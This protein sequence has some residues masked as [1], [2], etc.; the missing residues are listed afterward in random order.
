MRINWFLPFRAKGQ[1][2]PG[3]SVL[4]WLGPTWL[5]SPLRRWIQ[6][7]S[8]GVF[9]WLLFYVAWPYTAR[10][11]RTWDGWTPVEADASTGRV[12]VEGGHPPGAAAG[13][14]RVL[15]AVDRS[16]GPTRLLGAFRIVGKTDGRIDL[17]PTGAMAP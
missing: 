4:S 5:A 14:G 12:S 15:Y 6:I 2:G 10:P 7:G 17:E 3:G 1:W 13:P 8:W 16:G 9:A 11:A